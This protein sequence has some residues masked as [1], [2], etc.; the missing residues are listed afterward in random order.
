MT[1]ERD[2]RRIES[3]M[4]EEERLQKLSHAAEV[5]R[6]I[7]A[8]LGHDIVD[9]DKLERLAETVWVSVPAAQ[10]GKFTSEDWRKAIYD[11]CTN[12]LQRAEQ[13]LE[14]N[15]TDEK[16]FVAKVRFLRGIFAKQVHAAMLAVSEK[17]RGK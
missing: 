3:S 13:S 16:L 2:R 7:E 6:D 1:S 9:Q 10:R 14:E 11:R 5:R 8:T 17:Y 12:A 4:G 15:K